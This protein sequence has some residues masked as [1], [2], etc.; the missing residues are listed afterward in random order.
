MEQKGTKWG[1][2][3]FWL[4]FFWPAG[5]LLLFKKLATDKSAMMSGRTGALSV[6]GWILIIFGALIA[7]ATMSALEG[8][9]GIAVFFL[10]WVA[11]GVLLL[12]KASK[13]K[14]T[15][16]KFK[17]YIEIVVNQNVRSI[18]NV[19]SAVGLP[20]DVAVKDLQDMIN[21]GYLKDAYIDHGSR[22]ISLR[23][24]VSTVYAQATGAHQAAPQMTA[25]RCHG[26]GANNVTV[27]GGVSECEYCGTPINA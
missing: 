3:V 6:I 19:A 22:E 27:V 26:C 24:H 17:K 14:R 1:W 8:L 4:I 15:A 5:L 10:I 21:I 7:I 18:D 12:R 11:G 2:I 9:S 20:Y 25:A 23:Q 13:T 16:A